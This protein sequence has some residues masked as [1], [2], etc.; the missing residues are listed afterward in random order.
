M[1]LELNRREQTTL[2]LVT[3]DAE[4]AAHAT[5]L[6]N[7]RDGRIESDETTEE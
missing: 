5:R 4:L 3:H 1:L 7:L 6:I 2:I